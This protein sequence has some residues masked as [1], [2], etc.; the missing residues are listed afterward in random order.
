MNIN[1]PVARENPPTKETPT[2]KNQ[3]TIRESTETKGRA[4]PKHPD[5]DIKETTP[6]NLIEFL[7]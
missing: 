6:L 5:K 3:S 7:T 1:I 4:T 2:G